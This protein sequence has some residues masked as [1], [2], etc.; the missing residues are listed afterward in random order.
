M[1]KSIQ[2]VVVIIVIIIVRSKAQQL[3]KSAD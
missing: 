3:I 1:L 2:V